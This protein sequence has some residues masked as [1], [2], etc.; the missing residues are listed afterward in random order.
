MPCCDIEQFAHEFAYYWN[1]A[2]PCPSPVLID[3]KRA[4]HDW[5]VH[6]CTGAE[7]VR[8]QIGTLKSEGDYLWLSGQDPS[9]PSGGGPAR[10]QAPRPVLRPDTRHKHPA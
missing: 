3:W 8:E 9:G 2:N 4:L 5:R 1:Q 6:H 7:A 10:P